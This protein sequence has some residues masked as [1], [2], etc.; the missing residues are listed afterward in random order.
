MRRI[1]ITVVIL[2]TTLLWAAALPSGAHWK[3]QYFYDKEDSSFVINDFSF[4]SPQRGIAVGYIDYKKSGPKPMSII[5]RDGGTTWAEQPLKDIPQSLFLLNDSLGWMV[6]EKGIWQT[7]ESGRA[8]NKISKERGLLRVYFRDTLH[9]FAVG[10]RK[11]FLE[12]ADGG[13][14][15]KDVVIANPPTG[16]PDY[17]FYDWIEFANAKQAIVLGSSVPP[18]HE[19]T[20]TWMDPEA[21]ARRRELPNLTIAIETRDGGKTW[22]AQTAPTFGQITRF[23]SSADGY[24]LSLIRFVNAFQW[25]SEV[26]LIDRKGANSRVFREK[27]RNVTDVAWLGTGRAIL[28][29]V[30]PPGRLYQ[31]PIPG[32]LHVL[33]STD[34]KKWTEMKVD[35]RGFG[36]RAM[37]AVI[38]EDAAWLATD[39]GQILRL[40]PQ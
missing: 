40:T 3:L 38:G 21:L 28:A 24:S 35:Y 8:W 30:E 18:R 5:T 32:K 16:N 7:E 12:T 19:R 9:G 17:T 4:S 11:Q 20:P 27:D 26:N 15:W 25:P 31:L 29:A 2:T 10:A 34:M 33:I 37:L 13:K 14:T 1:G 23:R 22:T 6:T 39:T 36:T